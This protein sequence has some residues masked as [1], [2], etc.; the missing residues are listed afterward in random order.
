MREYRALKALREGK[1]VSI[2]GVLFKATEE[3][4]IKPGDIYIAE[5]NTGPRLLT[6]KRIVG[7][8][9]GPDGFG[10]WIDAKE[11]PAYNYDIWE[12]V[13]VRRL[14]PDEE[15]E[16]RHSENLQL[17]R[18]ELAKGASEEEVANLLFVAGDYSA[19]QALE[20][21]KEAKQAFAI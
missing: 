4:E 6:A 19:H 1:A 16:Y 5:R 15:Q 18:D 2:K 11:F 20:L 10:G 12:C 17:T 21:I 14:T 9:E 7:P 8:G 3:E 13:R